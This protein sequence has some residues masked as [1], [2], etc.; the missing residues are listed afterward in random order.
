MEIAR[1][2]VVDK[3]VSEVFSYVTDIKREP[4]WASGII[5]SKMLT[6]PPFGVGSHNAA[7]VR[8]L[9]LHFD[10]TNTVLEYELNRLV[11]SK[12]ESG[13]NN[14]IFYY[15]FEP[16]SGVAGTNGAK[17]TIKQKVELGGA[18][19]LLKPL[20]GRWLDTSLQKDLQT[21]KK[22]LEATPYSVTQ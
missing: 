17:F 9:G 5:A 19:K 3:P 8:F 20:I 10:T 18:M 14:A 4:E 16:F 2:I 11:V 6:N 21:L 13:S 22:L 12:P 7:K 1:S 15:I